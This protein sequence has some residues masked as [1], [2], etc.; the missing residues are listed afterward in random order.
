MPSTIIRKKDR[1]TRSYLRSVLV[2]ILDLGGLKD[3]VF[4]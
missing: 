4:N 2:D 1:K 3:A